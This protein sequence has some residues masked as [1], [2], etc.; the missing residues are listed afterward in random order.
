MP[1]RPD[2][3]GLGPEPLPRYRARPLSLR[4]HV[5]AA[6]RHQGRTVT[7][8]KGSKA[9]MTSHFV[10]LRVRLAGRRPN[11]AADGTIPLV[12]LISYRRLTK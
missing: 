3:G 12:R 8:R 6:G 9:A 2:Y 11:P 10:L 5:L 7:W 4:E 1:H